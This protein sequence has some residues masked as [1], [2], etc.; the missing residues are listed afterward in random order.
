MRRRLLGH[1]LGVY[2]AGLCAYAMCLFI[3]A[4]ATL[5][6]AG[7]QRASNGRLRLA[8]ARGSLWSGTGQ[9]EIRDATGRSGVSRDLAWHFQPQSLLHGRLGFAVDLGQ[10]AK[11]FSLNISPWGLEIADADFVFPAAAL[12]FV[13]P[14]LALLAPTG[15]LLVHMPKISFAHDAMRGNLL[16][17]WRNAGSSLTPV[18]PLGD[19]ELR[20]AGEAD[21]LN[22]SLRTIRGPLH[23]EGKGSRGKSGPPVFFVTARIEAQYERQLAP[24]LRLIAIERSDGSFELQ[25][26]QNIGRMPGSAIRQL[27]TE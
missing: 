3:L 17:E 22:A 1:D 8:E 12:G 4:P 23:L 27:Q 13:L 26:N 20:L 24:F 10:A 11:R 19:Y 9:F 21:G 18:S 25:L 7:L 5:L 14:K 2:A 6:D 16:V 15:D